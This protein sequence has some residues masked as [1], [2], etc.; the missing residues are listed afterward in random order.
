MSANRSCGQAAMA[1]YV[2]RRYDR[3]IAACGE[4]L[5]LQPD[6]TLAL[7]YLSL[8]SQACGRYE[9]A[10]THLRR[11]PEG[12]NASPLHLGLLGGALARAG[13]LAEAHTVLAELEER[14]QREYISPYVLG[15]LYN[16]LG[17]FDTV[18]QCWERAHADRSP[19]A[20]TLLWPEWDTVRSTPRFQA[21]VRSMNFPLQPL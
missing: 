2:G 11:V 8:A 18:L 9:E 17:E 15:L 1:L 10:V 6:N 13:Q 7:W 21:V 14:R 16:G 4:A 12:N 5:D 20:I 19:M 3:S